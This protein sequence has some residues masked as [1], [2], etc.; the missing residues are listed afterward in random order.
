MILEIGITEIVDPILLAPLHVKSITDFF[1][2]FL[3]VPLPIKT[4]S[5]GVRVHDG[6]KFTWRSSPS[7]ESTYWRPCAWAASEADFKRIIDPHWEDQASLTNQLF[8][9][10]HAFA[11][12][13]TTYPSCDLFLVRLLRLDILLHFCAKASPL[14]IATGDGGAYCSTAFACPRPSGASDPYV[15]RSD[16]VTSDKV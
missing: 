11:S 14:G 5:L 10:Y 13:R 8:F 15:T 7:A 9:L 1:F 12:H 16:R 2:P 6:P 3:K 4:L